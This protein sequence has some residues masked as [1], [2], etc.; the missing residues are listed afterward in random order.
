MFARY[1]SFTLRTGLLLAFTGFLPVPARAHGPFDHNAR[2][3]MLEDNLEVTVTL[4]PEAAKTFLTD[5]P[6]EVLR[7]GR[8]D[9]AFPLPPASAARLFEIKAGETL[10]SPVRATVRSDGLEYSFGLFY[11]R[12]ANGPLQFIARYVGETPSLTK[13]SLVVVDE[14]GTAVAGKVLSPENSSLEFTFSEKA[15]VA[16]TVKSE[17]IATAP[18]AINDLPTAVATVSGPPPAAGLWPRWR[19]TLIAAVVM[20]VALLIGLSRR[21]RQRPSP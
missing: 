17:V 20:T 8:M 15:G 3:W 2:V 18:T 13:G 16:P 11:P 14:N 6:A 4:G 21:T 7:S 12:P 10:L 9:L 1:F 19:L 5:G